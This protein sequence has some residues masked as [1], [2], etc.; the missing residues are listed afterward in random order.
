MHAI[1]LK[2]GIIPS[3]LATVGTRTPTTTR[4]NT[5]KGG[6][7]SVTSSSITCNCSH[8]SKMFIIKNFKSYYYF[9]N[10]K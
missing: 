5:T 2:N 8:S 1:C 7:P 6:I 3:Y 10:S 4:I 9:Q